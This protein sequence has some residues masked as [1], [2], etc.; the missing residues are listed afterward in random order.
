VIQDSQHGFTK[1]RLCLTN[2][3]TFYDEVTASVDKGNAYDVIYLDFCKDFDMIPHHILIPKL[4]RDRFERWTTQWIRNCLEGCSQR[5]VIND[6]VSR[7]RPVTSGVPQRSVLGPIFFDIFIT[8]ADDGIEHTFSK[9]A[10]DS[11]LS[12]SLILPIL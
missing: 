1:G 2:L 3:V 4:E 8:D 9:F 5:V 6:S 11:K 12:G 7:W 10:D